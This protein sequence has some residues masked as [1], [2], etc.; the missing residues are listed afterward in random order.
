MGLIFLI[1]F[2]GTG[3]T[4]AGREAAAMAGCGWDDLDD[5]IT[6]RIGCTISDFMRENSEDAFRQIES[7]E[8]D[9]WILRHRDRDAVLSCGGGVILRPGNVSKMKE[10]GTVIRLT[11]SPETVCGRVMRTPGTRPLLQKDGDQEAGQRQI[12]MERIRKMTAERE[13]RYRAAADTVIATDGLAPSETARLILR[14][15]GIQT[16]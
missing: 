5:L 14:A 4:A 13:D 12:L 11:A 10:A 9:A 3:K 15:A 8:L 16:I 6:E 7:S 2:M 1:G